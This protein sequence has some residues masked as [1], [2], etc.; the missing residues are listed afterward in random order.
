[1]NIYVSILNV[2][3]INEFINKLNILYTKFKSYSKLENIFNIGI[4]FDVMDN[5]FVPNVGVNLNSMLDIKKYG[6]YIDTHLMVQAP[7]EDDYINQAIKNGTDSIIIHY[8]IP[9]FEYVLDYLNDLKQKLYNDENRVLDI[10][11]SVKPNTDISNLKPYKDKF[12]KILIMS[13]EPGYGGQDYIDS[14]NEKIKAAK[15]MFPT[16]EIEID[17]GIN[18][19]TIIEPLETNAD[20]YVIGHYFTGN[21]DNMN[22]LSDKLIRLNVIK[23]I[24]THEKDRNIE[25]DKKLLQIV[26]GGYGYGDSLI[27]IKVPSVRNISKIWYKLLSLKNIDYFICSNYH[28]Y[29]QFACFCMSYLMDEYVKNSDKNNIV[30]LYNL[31]KKN[32]KYI[33]NWDLT[34]DSAPKILGNY[35]LLF[36]NDEK[37]N[38]IDEYLLSDNLWIKRIGI[39]SQLNLISNSIIDI[40]LKV[41]EKALY[42]KEPLLQKA[43]GWILRQIYK[44]DSTLIIEFLKS[45]YFENIIP[46]ITLSYACEK[47]SKADK[48]YIK[49][50]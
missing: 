39:V 47:M 20:S 17:G 27:G 1:M 41:C 7:I 10:G 2:K 24:W 32:L 14:I 16:H 9:N 23:S 22:D 13:V 28:E 45:K 15:N 12:S 25:F 3:D 5:K 37:L 49:L 4:H 44:E 26:D 50:N 29:R 11:I 40:P 48:E 6:L 8:E 42:F 38:I 33:N 19:N 18:D 30:K 36:N 43:T 35:L 34:D 21:E 46:S 31:Y